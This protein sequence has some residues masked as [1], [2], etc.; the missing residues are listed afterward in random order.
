[1]AA[2]PETGAAGWGEWTSPTSQ[3]WLSY[4]AGV[5]W[6]AR[7]KVFCYYSETEGLHIILLEKIMLYNSGMAQT[8]TVA[9]FIIY[10]YNVCP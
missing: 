10:K 4:P 9:T 2:V 8:V 3:A 7:K 5:F 6:G 1:M